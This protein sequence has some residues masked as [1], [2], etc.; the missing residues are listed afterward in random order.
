MIYLSGELV[1]LVKGARPYRLRKA[2][3]SEELGGAV[4]GPGFRRRFNRSNSA[5]ASLGA[6]G[7][8][9]TASWANHQLLRAFQVSAALVSPPLSSPSSPTEYRRKDESGWS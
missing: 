8:G 9:Q 3:I 6:A 1:W 4:L 2:L 5:W 7:W